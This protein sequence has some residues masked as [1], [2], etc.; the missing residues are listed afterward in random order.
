L[1]VVGA[2]ALIA[3]APITSDLSLADER[4]LAGPR[5]V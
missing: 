2:A 5:I 4:R 1:P 3:R